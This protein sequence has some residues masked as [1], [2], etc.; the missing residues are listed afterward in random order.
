VARNA[1]QPDNGLRPAAAAGGDLPGDG[2]GQKTGR[3]EGGRGVLRDGK[4][5]DQALDGGPNALAR[6]DATLLAAIG[7]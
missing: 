1:A 7:V 3:S 5:Q 6:G 4:L 2:L